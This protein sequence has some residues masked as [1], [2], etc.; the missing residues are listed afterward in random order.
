MLRRVLSVLIAVAVLAPAA[1]ARPA[2]KRFKNCQQ[3]VGYAQRHAQGYQPGGPPGQF[4]PQPV[5]TGGPEGTVAPTAA[6]GGSEDAAD[7]SYSVTNNQEQGVFEP[8]I[9][10]TDG[11]HIYTVANGILHVIDTSNAAPAEIGTLTLTDPGYNDQLLLFHGRLLIAGP[12]PTGSGTVLRLVDVSDPAHPAELRRLVVDGQLLA[13]RRTAGTVRVVLTSIPRAIAYPQTAVPDR[14][15]AWTPRGTFIRS[16]S[17]RTSTR[18][19]V[20]CGHVRR[21]ASFSGLESLTV[22]TIDMTSSPPTQDPVDA[23]VVMSSGDTVY[24]SATNLYV[25]THRYEPQL[26]DRTDGDVPDNE[27]TQLHRFSL[28]DANNT[29]YRATGSLPGF[30]LNQFSLSED[31]DIL[32][33]ATTTTP[34]WFTQGE[35]QSAVTTFDQDLHK[36]GS[37]DGLGKGERIYAV[38]FLGDAGYV[39]TFRQTDP[40]FTLDLSDPAHPALKGEL[41]LP[42]FSSYL[43]PIAGDRMI[44]IGTGPN[45]DNSASGLQLSLFDV[46]DLANPRLEKRI[47]IANGSSVAQY[48]HHAFLWW[49]P[50]NLAVLPVDQYDSSSCCFATTPPQPGSTSPGKPRAAIAPS[51]GFQG[52]IGYTVGA[53]NIAEAGRVGGASVQRTLIVNNR[54]YSLTYTSLKASSLDDFSD[55]GEV[56]WPQPT[57]V[58]NDGGVDAT[59]PQP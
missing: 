34:P 52:A 56:D 8:D 3:L 23:D 32:R 40:L 10:K 21:P 9:V 1:Q 24:A 6:A 4:R 46:S 45:D 39:V 25:A 44:G 43:H 51:G 48:D 13:E 47:T 58:V 15:V 19:I 31:K 50:K 2:L 36:V 17:G 22:L 53:G 49:A 7:G 42:G 26:E 57:P 20:A 16:V 11:T 14:P 18:R 59:P 35:S 54:L 55:L 38:R 33:V 30:V 12:D 29:T 41:V 28:D 27:T 37:V 5:F